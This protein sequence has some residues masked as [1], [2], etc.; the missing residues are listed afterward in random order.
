MCAALP[1]PVRKVRLLR[2]VFAVYRVLLSSRPATGPPPRLLSAGPAPAPFDDRDRAASHHSY[3]FLF[4]NITKGC[5]K[6]DVR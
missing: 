4:V 1:R 2:Y 5:V 3:Y 6:H